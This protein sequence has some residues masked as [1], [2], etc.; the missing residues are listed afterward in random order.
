MNRARTRAALAG[1]VLGASGAAAQDES[2]QG[3]VLAVFE[4]C[5]GGLVGSLEAMRSEFPGFRSGEERLESVVAGA[6][7][8]D[9]VGFLES[10]RGAEAL[11]DARVACTAADDVAAVLRELRDGQ[12]DMAGRLW[13]RWF[14]FEWPSGWRQ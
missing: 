12:P 14:P 13:E 11:D 1:L 9:P 3:E 8:A 7:H 5:V 4:G 2:L 10:R 6:V